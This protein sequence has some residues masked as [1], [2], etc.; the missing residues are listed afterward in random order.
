MTY[1]EARRIYD[2]DSA[3]LESL[4]SGRKMAME[5]P[6]KDPAKQAESLAKVDAEINRLSESIAKV[7][8]IVDKV[9]PPR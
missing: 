3:K 6:L 5:L 7:K 4:I 8:P 9:T 1:A 2:E